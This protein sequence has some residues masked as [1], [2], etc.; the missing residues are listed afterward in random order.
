MTFDELIGTELTAIGAGSERVTTEGPA[1]V[2]LRSSTVQTLALAIHELA[3]N[4]SKYGALVQPNGRL[5]VR[6]T[7]EQ[8]APS[9]KPWLHIDWRETGLV[10]PPSDAPAR[11]TGHGRELIEKAL[12]YQLGA[13]TSY[14][15][16]AD[17]VH[18]TISIPVS[19]TGKETEHA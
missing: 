2:R 6:W 8:A 14:S 12:P 1:G 17:G 13:K 16:E 7:F 9:A 5:Q 4:A 18:C 11:G 10:M 19:T 3:T 15:F